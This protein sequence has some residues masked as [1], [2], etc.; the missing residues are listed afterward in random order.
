[1]ESGTKAFR[2]CIGTHHQPLLRWS[3]LD[4]RGSLTFPTVTTCVATV[5]LDPV[6]TRVGAAAEEGVGSPCPNA[7]RAREAK[8]KERAIDFILNYIL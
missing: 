6:S 4:G 8:N 2:A 1:M 5:E 3:V 7:T